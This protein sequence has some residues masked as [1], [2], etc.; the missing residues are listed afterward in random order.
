MNLDMA[1][2]SLRIVLDTN[3]LISAIHFGGKPREILN[4]VEDPNAAIKA[5]TSPVLLAELTETFTKKFNFD[6]E[7]IG[8]ITNTIGNGFELVYP[9]KELHVVS[10]K[11]DN[12]VLEAAVAGACEIIITGDRELLKLEKFKDIKIMTAGQFLENFKS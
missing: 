1:A 5:V 2:S 11:D 4:L 8:E 9:E 3:I 12:R 7:H 10:D 6:E